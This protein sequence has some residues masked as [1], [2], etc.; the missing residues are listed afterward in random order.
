M[1]LSI[2]EPPVWKGRGAGRAIGEIPF[3]GI[4]LVKDA[5]IKCDLK[6]ML[7]LFKE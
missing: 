4:C 2:G 7:I 1:P 3:T 5:N 6:V